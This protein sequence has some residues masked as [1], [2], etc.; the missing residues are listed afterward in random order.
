VIRSTSHSA[1]DVYTQFQ[2]ISEVTKE[3][4]ALTHSYVKSKDYSPMGNITLVG[5]LEGKVKDPFFTKYMKANNKYFITV[6]SVF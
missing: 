5:S 1:E 2:A 4:S 6:K 3:M